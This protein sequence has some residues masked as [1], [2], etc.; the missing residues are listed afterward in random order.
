MDKSF[1]I[2][3]TAFAGLTGALLTQLMTGLFAYIN[4]RRKQK[5]DL[6]NQYRIKRLEIGENFYFINGELMAII[7]KNI[8]Y[9]YNLRN[10]RSE[11][12]LIS[13]KKEI[14]KL[15]NY[16]AQLRTENWKYNLVGIYFRVPFGF[17]AIQEANSRSH[18]LCILVNDL[19]NKI[20]AA[21]PAQREELYKSYNVAIFDLCSHYEQVFSRMQDNMVAIKDQL[22]GEFDM[23]KVV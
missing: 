23:R 22:L 19:A 20:R 12:T 9:W 3:V 5:V 11:Q 10:D 1:V 16:Q 18:Q 15:D 6:E 13:M 4:D 2:Y 21:A 14:G 8:D 17:D 7:R